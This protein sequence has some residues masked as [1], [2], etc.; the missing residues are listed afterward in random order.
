MD[1]E[2]VPVIIATTQRIVGERA[3]LNE[4]WEEVAEVISPERIG[5]TTG[6][7]PD[8]RRTDKIFDTQ[9]VTAKRGLVNALGSMLR[10][11]SAA[12]GK[13]YDIVPEDEELLDD[14]EVKAWIE[15]AE[16]KLWKAL[17][18]PKAKFIEAT[19]EIDDDI[20]SFGTG[21]GF[22]GTREDQSGPFY[23]SFHM[24]NIYCETDSQNNINAVYVIEKL[25]AAQA[26]DRWGI[27]NLGDKTQEELTRLGDAG[28]SKKFDFYWCVK[29]RHKYD[30]RFKGNADMPFGSYVV[31]V[32]SE[33]LVLEEGFEDF[34]F[35]IPRWDTRS[36][37]IYGRGPGV[38]A[39][40]DVLTL[41]QM[42]KTMLRGLGRAVDP[43]W[44]LPAD[45]FVNAPQM[46]QGGVSYY[47]AKAVRNLG[48]SD[49]FKQMDSRAQIPWGLNAQTAAREQIHALFY[50]NVLNLPVSAPQMTATEVIQRREEFVREIG[51][52]FGRME[53]D[54]T[55]PIVE[56][57]F[58]MM[59]RKGSFGDDSQIPE[60]IQDQ[61]IN[62]R[63]ASPIEK[64]KAQIEE[65]TVMEGVNKVMAIGQVQPQ[66]MKRFNWDEIGK[67]L[68]KSGD[69][70]V[71]LTLDDEQVEQLQAQED[72]EMARQQQLDQVKQVTD[73]AGSLPPEVLG[74]VDG[75]GGGG[76]G[77]DQEGEPPQ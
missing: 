30:P 31:D 55:G 6:S 54:Y 20:V 10:P 22:V 42:G 66:I 19:G 12:P 63:F 69:F 24:K 21:A 68:A 75:G 25:T 70:P 65:A 36:G 67:F 26:A 5:F 38:L 74:S 1:K 32:D 72:Q 8:N 58:N 73:M 23:R 2:L 35:F 14:S 28:S 45:S 52:V 76:G 50:R 13:W 15:F 3:Q 37:E 39:L 46:Q 17:Y 59:L 48:I 27:D 53:S 34:P 18:N 64:A 33:H 51:A 11:K 71:E 40:P 9:P 61:G 49:P 29:P 43:P 16:D 41:N 57:T 44:L 47:D 4:L 60:A 56:R 62:F 77:L 7:V